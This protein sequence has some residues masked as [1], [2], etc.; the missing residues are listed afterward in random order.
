[1]FIKKKVLQHVCL[2]IRYLTILDFHKVT[3]VE[4]FNVLSSRTRKANNRS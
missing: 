4:F 1:M 2:H 3:A